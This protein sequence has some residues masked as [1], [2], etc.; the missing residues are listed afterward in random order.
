MA[1]ISNYAKLNSVFPR[2]M[3]IVIDRYMYFI[4]PNLGNY[5]LFPHAAAVMT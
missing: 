1:I 5:F 2:M 3:C 4:D